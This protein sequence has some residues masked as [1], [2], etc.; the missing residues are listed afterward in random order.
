MGV[1]V[2]KNALGWGVIVWLIGYVM[3]IVLFPIVPQTTIGWIIL[4][5]GLAVAIWVLLRKVKPETLRHFVV[6]AVLWT[7]VAVLFDYLFI[8]RAF[9]PADGYYKPDVYLYYALTFITPLAIGAWRSRA[10][11]HEGIAG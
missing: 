5:V 4:P 7:I 10:V 2:L 1:P 3:D 6:L 8:V 11:S 9:H